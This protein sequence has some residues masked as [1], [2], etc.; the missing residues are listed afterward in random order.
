[1]NAATAVATAA[2]IVKHFGFGNC[3]NCFLTREELATMRE[4]CSEHAHECPA[5]AIARLSASCKT[6]AAQ[7]NPKEVQERAQTAQALKEQF[8]VETA[9]KDLEAYDFDM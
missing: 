5:A 3:E 7:R 8:D 4:G 1:M 2:V 6:T 9:M